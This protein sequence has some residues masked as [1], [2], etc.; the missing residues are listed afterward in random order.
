M[1]DVN[2]NTFFFLITPRFW[3]LSLDATGAFYRKAEKQGKEELVWMG[4]L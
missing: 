1:K 3:Y 4:K 2:R